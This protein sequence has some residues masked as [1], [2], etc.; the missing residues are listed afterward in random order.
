M[1]NIAALL[2]VHNSS[3]VNFTFVLFC[4]QW[5]LERHDWC[6]VDLFDLANYSL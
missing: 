3:F 1:E 6:T 4:M 2:L 5:I